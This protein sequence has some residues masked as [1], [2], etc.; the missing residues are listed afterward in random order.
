MKNLILL[1]LIFFSGQIFAQTSLNGR[2]FEGNEDI[3]ISFAEVKL[4]QNGN[5][6]AKTNTDIDGFYNF[7][8]F[9]AG[10]F[11]I[12]I[13]SIGYASIRIDK[14]ILYMQEANILDFTLKKEKGISC[15]TTILYEVPLIKFD[16]TTS[17]STFSSSDLKR[18]YHGSLFSEK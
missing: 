7:S 3:G 11:E 12:E 16:Q 2:V 6:I 5:L 8:N 4:Y 14:V 13:Q 18:L 17:G 9:D 15:G 1:I 10:T